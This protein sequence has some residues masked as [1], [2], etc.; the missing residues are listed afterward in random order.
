MT[1]PATAREAPTTIARMV[2]WMRSPHTTLLATELSCARSPCQT[3]SGLRVREPRARLSV[4]STRRIRTASSGARK[5]RGPLR[6]LVY[7]GRPGRA[8]A[9]A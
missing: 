3:S 6:C 2:R 8:G 1:T 4:I 7:R 5:R 9:S